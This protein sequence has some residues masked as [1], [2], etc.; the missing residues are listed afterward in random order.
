M[1]KA[2]ILMLLAVFLGCTDTSDQP[3]PLS[4]EGKWVD[5]LT[6]TD[7]LEFLRL[8][9]GSSLL[10]LSRGRENRNG[11]NLPKAG[12]GL[13]TFSL[14][15]NSIT[16]QYSFSSFYDPTDYYFKQ[17]ALELKVGRFFDSENSSDV[18]IFRKVR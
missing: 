7:T 12:S 3:V 14:G 13:Y 10:N 15:K 4:L 11:H 1:E 17:N 18:L 5:P 6:K 9:D 2:L 8:E 16:L